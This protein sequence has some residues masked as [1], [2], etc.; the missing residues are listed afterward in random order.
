M[1]A[2]DLVKALVFAAVFIGLTALVP[3]AARR[4]VSAVIVA[5]AAATY[6]NGGLGGWEIAYLIA[7]LAVAYRGLD[8]YRWI[9]LAWA[10]HS[11]W[12]L[13]HH[14]AGHELI[15]FVPKSSL[16]CALSDPWIALWF[17]LGAPTRPINRVAAT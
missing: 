7:A 11:G 16:G 9:G 13:V 12:D 15:D 6:L 3:A 10:M 4:R 17:L 8:S 14:L 5:G 1:E 2:L